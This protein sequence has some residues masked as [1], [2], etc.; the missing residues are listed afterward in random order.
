[1]NMRLLAT[2]KNIIY[3]D[4]FVSEHTAEDERKN[5]EGIALLAA[6]AFA[7][8]SLLNIKQE[9][10]MMLGTTVF[11]TVLFALG[12]VF[13]HFLKKPALLR[14][15]YYITFILVFTSYTIVGGNDGFAVLWLIIA[16]YAVMISIDFKAGFLISLYYL[17]MLLLVFLGP[18]SFL[19]QYQYEPT[20]MLRFPFLYL[21]NFAF[22]TY[23]SIRI[24]TYQYELLLKREELVTLSTTDLAT[25]L[26]NRNSFIRDMRSFPSDGAKTLTAV[27]IDINGL[28]EMNNRLGHAAGDEMIVRVAKLCRMYFPDAMIYRMGGDEF[29]IL[30]K[31]SEEQDVT[32]AVHRLTEEVEHN[33]YSVAFGVETQPAPFDLDQIVKN[34]DLKMVDYKNRYYMDAR[35]KGR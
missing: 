22:A 6:A 11:G 20:F 5:Q 34:A 25:G 32:V 23:I 17:I 9:S 28:H 3:I 16:T 12:F 2:I 30:C 15:A 14:T 4:R 13:S 8:M 31:D 33:D 1:M 24:R 19:L 27:F 7:V 18:L 26:M 35:R 29:L 10:F 21:I